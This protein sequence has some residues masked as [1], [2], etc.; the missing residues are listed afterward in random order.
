MTDGD[1]GWRVLANVAMRAAVE[2]RRR[3]SRG[4]FRFIHFDLCVCYSICEFD[5]HFVLFRC[6]CSEVAKCCCRRQHSNRSAMKVRKK[7]EKEIRFFFI[8][9]V[10]FFKPKGRTG[11]AFDSDL[12]TNECF[13]LLLNLILFFIAVKYQTIRSTNEKVFWNSL[14]FLSN[15][16]KPTNYHSVVMEVIR[17]CCSVILFV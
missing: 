13:V 8:D 2:C 10:F 14:S 15:K 9:F 3:C 7:E 5:L 16:K 1:L 4:S 6:S 17:C 11:S 12:V